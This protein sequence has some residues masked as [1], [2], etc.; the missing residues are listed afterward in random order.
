MTQACSASP[1]WGAASPTPGAS[2]IVWARSSSSSCRYLPKLS[3]GNP[4]R[5]RRGS[6]NRAIGRTDM[7]RIIGARRF[8]SDRLRRL[9]LLGR[10]VGRGVGR[11][12]RAVAGERLTRLG[13]PGTGLLG[14]LA[15]GIGRG[16]AGLV[17]ERHGLVGCGRDSVGGLDGELANDGGGL[18]GEVLDGYPDRL[19]DVARL[20]GGAGAGV[21]VVRAV[22]STDVAVVG[23]RVGVAAGAL[24]GLV[25]LRGGRV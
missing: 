7:P 25:V 15:A 13:S 16:V 11:L 8:C 20:G 19:D 1:S 14:E 18:L 23:S 21:R 17:R 6:P 9:G 22:G 5:R 24:D 10:R 3:T 4:F 12:G 2:R